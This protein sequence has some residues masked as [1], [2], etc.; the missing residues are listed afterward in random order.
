MNFTLITP[1]RNARMF[2]PLCVASVADQRSG[3]VSLEHLIIDGASSD[4]SVDWLQKQTGLAWIS[5]PDAGMYDALNKG[6]ARATGEILAWLNADE[7]YLSGTL[8]KVRAAFERHPEADIVY[9]DTLVVNAENRLI[10]V[11]KGEP[12]RK[13][14]LLNDCLHVLTCGIFFRRRIWDDGFRFNSALRC[15]GENDFFLRVLQAGA[16]TKYLPEFLAAFTVT[17]RNLGVTE[18]ARTE[19][20]RLRVNRPAWMKAA[21]PL[22]TFFR[23]LEKGRNGAYRMPSELR[24]E[25]YEGDRGSRQKYT[26]TSVSYRWVEQEEKSHCE[27]RE[28]DE[29]GRA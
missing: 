4:G 3:K 29:R 11:R 7:Q 14:Y 10:C 20:A 26:A 23:R 8:E 24:Y 28:R 1:A 16:K 12:F 2:L 13:M 17:G 5:E 6:F 9:G 25:L 19:L 15:A 22:I 18:Q 21:K 27:T